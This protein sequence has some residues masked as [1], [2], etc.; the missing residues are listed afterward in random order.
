MPYSGLRL[1]GTTGSVI[2]DDLPHKAAQRTRYPRESSR[3]PRCYT[4]PLNALALV[5]GHVVSAA[6]V[7]ER[8]DTASTAAPTGSPRSA[9]EAILDQAAP[10]PEEAGL[11]HKLMSTLNPATPT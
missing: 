1:S 5:S 3:D 8:L 4:P 7:F 2:E 9:S 11:I 6:A 10:R